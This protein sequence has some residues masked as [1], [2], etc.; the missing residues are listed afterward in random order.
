MCNEWLGFLACANLC[1]PVNCTNVHLIGIAIHEIGKPICWLRTPFVT[2]TTYVCTVNT[3]ELY[4]AD[5]YM[6]I[7]ICVYI[8]VAVYTYFEMFVC[9]Y[10]PVITY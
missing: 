1:L 6:I 5:S 10:L 4:L 9:A 7:Y 3:D 2:A 8:Y